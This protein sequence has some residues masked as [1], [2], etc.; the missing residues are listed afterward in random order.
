[1]LKLNKI[2][3]MTVVILSTV[4]L[5]CSNSSEPL[6]FDDVSGDII[7]ETQEDWGSV[8]YNY[9]YRVQNNVWNKAAATGP[10]IQR[11]FTEKLNGKEALGW[12]WNWPLNSTN[13]VS[14]PEVIY[15]DKAWD[16]P[17]GIS[18]EFP[19]TAES[20]DIVSNFNVLISA[21]G[22]YNMAFSIWGYSNSSNPKGSIT[23]EI[24]IW[25]I[26]EGMLPAGT[27]SFVITV[28]GIVFDVYV[29]KN[30]G[31]ASGGTSNTWTYIAFSPRTNIYNGPL[32]IHEFTDFLI[33]KGILSSSTYLSSLELG[34]EVVGGK[35]TTEIENYS[36]TVT[37]R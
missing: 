15:G 14:Y 18:T 34:N 13:V 12:Q 28:N 5:S 16:E 23:H 7:D 27:K 36:V 33:S 10:Y 26:N 20:S 2:I 35:G 1:M 21:E 19:I 37:E 32:N 31:D 30:H 24:M 6:T 17:S 8:R 22:I 25:I 9:K 29:R 3:L 11:V 4:V